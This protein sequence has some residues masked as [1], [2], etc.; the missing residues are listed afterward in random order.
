[1]GSMGYEPSLDA[2]RGGSEGVELAFTQ[3]LRYAFLSLMCLVL[4]ALTISALSRGPRTEPVAEP[5][6][7]QRATRETAD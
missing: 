6:N 4:L 2:V 7:P 3:G 1:M 5:A